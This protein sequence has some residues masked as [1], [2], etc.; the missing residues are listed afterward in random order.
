M[1]LRCTPRELARPLYTSRL[2][3]RPG[4]MG[5][6]TAARG[7]VCAAMCGIA[8]HLVCAVSRWL[9]SF[10]L[11]DSACRIAWCSRC[12]MVGGD[13][14]PPSLH[15]CQ[16]CGVGNPRCSASWGG[17]AGF[18]AACALEVASGSGDCGLR[19]AR[20]RERA[21]SRGGGDR[22]SLDSFAAP[23]HSRCAGA[24]CNAIS[25]QPT[26]NPSA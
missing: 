20:N 13:G 23:S 16:L 12:W 3:S 4:P 9:L 8:P 17:P 5:G 10:A 22:C 19:C 11:A 1:A 25:Q 7:V 24:T 18:A 14:Q 21:S 2:R 6:S 15:F 26:P